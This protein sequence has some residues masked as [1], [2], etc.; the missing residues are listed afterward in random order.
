MIKNTPLY[1]ATVRTADGALVI[2][3]VIEWPIA[4]NDSLL[5]GAYVKAQHGHPFDGQK[6]AVVN[7]SRMTDF[8][9]KVQS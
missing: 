6:M 7:Q 1:C 9:A 4:D 5:P 8:T 2:C 3:D